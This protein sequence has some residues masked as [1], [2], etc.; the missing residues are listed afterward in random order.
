M[1]RRKG[2]ERKG[3]ERKGRKNERRKMLR[4]NHRHKFSK[5][6]LKRVIQGEVRNY[7]N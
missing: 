3:K 7:S 2:K 4:K 5:R 1:M 6:M